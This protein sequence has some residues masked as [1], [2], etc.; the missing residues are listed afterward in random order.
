MV[1]SGAAV[2][3]GL[4]GLG[5]G[6]ASAQP[7]PEQTDRTYRRV[8]RDPIEHTIE[9]DPEIHRVMKGYA[10]D[11]I[12]TNFYDND[13]DVTWWGTTS[14]VENRADENRIHS[15]GLTSEEGDFLRSLTGLSGGTW[16]NIDLTSGTYTTEYMPGLQL[17]DVTTEML[18]TTGFED[19]TKTLDEVTETQIT[20]EFDPENPYE[21]IEVQQDYI[22][23]T[24]QRVEYQVI[25]AVY[26]GPDP[27]GTVLFEDQ[28]SDGTS[29]LIQLTSLPNGGFITITDTEG[30][31]L[32]QSEELEPD[33]IYEDLE[34]SLDPAITS[35][36]TLCATA[37]VQPGELYTR[38]DEPIVDCAF[39]TLVDDRKGRKKKRAVKRKKCEYD[40]ARKKYKKRKLSEKG[41]KKKRSAYKRA[42]R[43]YEKYKNRCG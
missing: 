14:V 13:W 30:N 9:L 7:E 11:N 35:S 28:L 4:T 23:R 38:N 26:D 39:I 15:V 36:Q 40:T 41:L 1:G 24:I 27:E 19:Y 25:A 22:Y 16:Y 34:I 43:E 29:V 33:T 20:Y 32:G 10:V 17:D 3:S 6:T 8:V 2:G 37:Y 12:S 18:E 21:V 5:A 31:V 42:K